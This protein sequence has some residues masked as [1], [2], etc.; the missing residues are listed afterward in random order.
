MWLNAQWN[1]IWID[2]SSFPHREEKFTETENRTWIIVCVYVAQ[3]PE[4]EIS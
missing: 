2:N 1:K 3:V 4:G